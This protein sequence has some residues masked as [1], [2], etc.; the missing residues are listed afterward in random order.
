[1]YFGQDG[2]FALGE[3]TPW[4]TVGVYL[5]AACLDARAPRSLTLQFQ[6]VVAG[7]GS[8]TLVPKTLS[9]PLPQS[10]G[11]DNDLARLQKELSA[12]CQKAA[13]KLA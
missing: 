13:I 8:T 3:F 9:L 10:N 12:K 6:K 1:V 4:L 7:Y 11:V 2:L 5:E